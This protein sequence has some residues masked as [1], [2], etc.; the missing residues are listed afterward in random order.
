MNHK[1]RVYLHYHTIAQVVVGAIIGTILGCA[2]YYFVNYQFIK[3]V[4][5][6]IEQP[7]AKIFL[8]RDYAPIP[9]LIH[10]QYESEYSEAK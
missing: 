8:V 10:F 5:W 1:F 3:Y 7:L 4:P 6:I 2:W 9:R